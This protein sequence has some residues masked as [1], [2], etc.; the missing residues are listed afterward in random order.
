[1]AAIRELA[2]AIVK[3]LFCSQ[4]VPTGGKGAERLVLWLDSENKD[5]GGWAKEPA[6]DEIERIIRK[7]LG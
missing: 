4:E 5:L 7:F 3:G 2:D 6:R 1:M